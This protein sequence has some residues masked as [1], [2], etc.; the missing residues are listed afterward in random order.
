VRV[1]AQVA[2]VDSENPHTP[3]VVHRSVDFLQS[4][5]SRAFA[6]DLRVCFSHG[7]LLE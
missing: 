6:A 4:L 5:V 2:P 1:S 3:P 7:M